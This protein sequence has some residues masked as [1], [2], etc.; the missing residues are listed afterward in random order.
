MGTIDEMKAQI[1]FPKLEPPPQDFLHQMEEY[2][3]EA[4]RAFEPGPAAGTGTGGSTGTPGQPQGAK[5]VCSGR[6]SALNAGL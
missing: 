6:A 1:Q 4:P 5:K 2:C 3:R